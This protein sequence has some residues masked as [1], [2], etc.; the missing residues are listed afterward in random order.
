MNLKKL[1]PDQFRNLM[2]GA[3]DSLVS[4]VGV[5]FGVS[6][7]LHSRPTILLTGLVVIAVEALSMGAG[8]YLSEISTQELTK[9]K[10]SLKPIGDGIIM[11][12]SYLITGFIPLLPYLFFDIETGRI[13]SVSLTVV[14]LFVLGF[15]PGKK[16]KAGLRMVVIAGIAIFVGYL[17]GRFVPLE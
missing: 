17:I 12:F 10:A 13:V 4:T 2:F 8:A 1:H 6:T 3:E 11:F 16:V 5:L 9:K 14:A 15:I 7:A